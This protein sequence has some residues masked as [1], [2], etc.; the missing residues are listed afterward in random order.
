M[1]SIMC[2][3]TRQRSR[4]LRKRIP[5]PAPSAAPSIKP[6]MSATTKLFSGSTLTTP[7]LGTSVVNG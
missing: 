2:S 3:S 4:C 7:R 6:G 1:I 5:K